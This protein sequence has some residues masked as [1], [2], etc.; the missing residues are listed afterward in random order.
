MR[1]RKE[2]KVP[3]IKKIRLRWLYLR[4]RPIVVV[5]VHHS[6]CQLVST[7][8]GRVGFVTKQTL[9][10]ECVRGSPK[11]E[12]VGSRGLEMKDIILGA[13][14]KDG[15]FPNPSPFIIVEKPTGVCYSR[16]S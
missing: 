13:L 14:Q 15:F 6:F 8:L 2:F 10:L 5:S 4:S 12:H 7:L 11:R 3:L 16:L 9:V 1:V